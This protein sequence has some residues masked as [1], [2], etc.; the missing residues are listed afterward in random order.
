MKE[1]YTT[2]KPTLNFKSPFREK[3][4][5]LNAARI[6]LQVVHNLN[7]ITAKYHRYVVSGYFC[8]LTTNTNKNLQHKRQI[9][10][11]GQWSSLKLKL[12]NLSSSLSNCQFKRSLLL[13]VEATYIKASLFLPLMFTKML[14][15]GYHTQGCHGNTLCLPSASYF[16]NKTNPQKNEN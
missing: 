16:Q 7:W 3:S 1:K 2:Y 13:Y 11:T 14:P 6:L 10:K 15:G 9:I 12:I 4:L 8:F 5:P